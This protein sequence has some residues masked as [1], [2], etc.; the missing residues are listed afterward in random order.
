[1]VLIPLPE[2]FS[3][4][5]VS[6]TTI[7]GG[8]QLGMVLDPFELIALAR[9]H[10]QSGG[11]EVF[12]TR[13]SVAVESSEQ[14]G[15]PLPPAG[16][17]PEAAAEEKP[18]A[19]P[20]G[21]AETRV[22]DALAE[23]FFVEIQDILK[24]LN[25]D[26]F[27][28]EKDPD[29]NQRINTIFRHFHSVKGNLIMTGFNQLGGFVHQV[30]T[31]LDRI[32]DKELAIDNEIIDLLLDAVKTLEKALSEIRAGRNFEVTDPDLLASLEQYRRQETPAEEPDE[33]AAEGA[34]RFGPLSQLILHAKQAQGAAVYQ[35]MFRI[36]PRFQEPF[37]V[38]YLILKRL[39]LIGDVI[40]TVPPLDRIAQG[41]VS[42][43]I[44]VMFATSRPQEEVSRFIDKQL[45]RYY[46]VVQ[47]EIMRM[48]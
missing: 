4:R 2:I 38:A 36:E 48:E 21:P 8:N 13:E 11:E 39:G 34:F 35:C 1:L 14:A 5:G 17:G 24:E 43:R 6:G 9:G 15:P 44:K 45:V 30:E 16:P 18:A 25:E 19:P 28:L 22:D 47:H 23:E 7:L 40:D 12:L 10:R 46:D 37:L 3:V 27:Q 26:I 32:R 33:D 31:V 42:D 41:L 29:N 20:E